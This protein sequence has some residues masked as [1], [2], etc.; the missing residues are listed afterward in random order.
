V[1]TGE[2]LAAYLS[3]DL[4]ADERTALEAELAGDPAL[5]ARLDRIRASDVTLADL[6]DPDLPHGFSERLRDRLAPEVDAVLGDELAARRARRTMPGWLPAAGAAALAVVVAVGVATVGGGGD[7]SADML[8]GGE[9]ATEAEGGDAAADM[10][11]ESMLAPSG[12]IVTDRG[13]TL[14]AE[15]LASLAQDP[16]VRA[17]LSGDALAT[18]PEAAAL[19]YA[20]AL[21]APLSDAPMQEF[22]SDRAAAGSESTATESA[23]VADGAAS[24]GPLDRAVPPVDVRGDVS[25]ADRE[26]VAAC[27]PTLFEAVAVPVVPVYAELATD[28]DGAQVIVIA[29]LSRNADGEFQRLEVWMLDRDTCEP[30]LFVQSDTQPVERN[31]P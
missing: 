13:R 5:R 24:T 6:P 22:D 1:D 26:A 9:A 15:D 10:E 17:V 7:D 14:T 12:P 29:A 30:R 3:G 8:A 27:V 21:G 4:D 31:A 25:D 28:E 18:D 2:R 19:P 20:A 11:E 16:D 23:D